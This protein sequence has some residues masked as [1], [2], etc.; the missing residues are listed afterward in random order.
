MEDAIFKF[1]ETKRMIQLWLLQIYL[2][3]LS[4]YIYLEMEMEEL[5]LA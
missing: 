4:I 1:H 2:E 5:I 3:T